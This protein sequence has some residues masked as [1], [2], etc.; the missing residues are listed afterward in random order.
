M[1]TKHHKEHVKVVPPNKVESPV[2]K[3][4]PNQLSMSFPK[5]KKLSRKARMLLNVFQNHA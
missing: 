3:V 5:D 1:A 4:I 2:T